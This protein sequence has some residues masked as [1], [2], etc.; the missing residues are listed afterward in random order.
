[1]KGDITYMNKSVLTDLICPICGFAL[2]V[3]GENDAS[4]IMCPNCS[5]KVVPVN[6]STANRVDNASFPDIRNAPAIFAFVDTYYESS[7]DDDFFTSAD[8]FSVKM[9]DDAVSNALLFTASEPLAW[10]AEAERI[11]LP[12]EKKLRYLE[13]LPDKI[14]KEHLEDN[15]GE[16]NYLFDIYESTLLSF[17]PYI[18][19]IKPSLD[20]ALE[21]A[22]KFGMDEGTLISL[23]ERFDSLQ[24]RVSDLCGNDNLPK[25]PVLLEAVKEARAKRD[26]RITEALIAMG[27]SAEDTYVSAM[28]L[29]KKKKNAQALDMFRQLGTYKDSAEHIAELDSYK[30]FDDIRSI[31][32]K[33]YLC[34]KNDQSSAKKKVRPV[35]LYD[36]IPLNEQNTSLI[37]IDTPV[38]KIIATYADKIYYLNREKQLTCLDLQDNVNRSVLLDGK[39]YL[40]DTDTKFHSFNGICKLAVAAREQV[41]I[42]KGR[43]KGKLRPTDTDLLIIDLSKEEMTLCDFGIDDIVCICDSYI[44]YCKDNNALS[45]ESGKVLMGYNVIT[46]KR[47]TMPQNVYKVH[48]VVDEYIIFSYQKSSPYNLSL[49]ALSCGVTTFERVLEDNVLDFSGVIDKKIYY[50]VGSYDMRILCRIDPVTLE[51]REIQRGIKARSGSEILLVREGWMYFKKG[52]GKNTVLARCHPNGSDYRVVCNDFDRFACQMPFIRGYLYYIDTDGSLCR[53]LISGHSQKVISDNIVKDTGILSF[54]GGKICFARNEYA[55]KCAV[56]KPASKKGAASTIVQTDKYSL[57]LYCCELDGTN[58]CKLCFDFDHV[59]QLSKSSLLIRR[60]MTD[61]FIAKN[62]RTVIE[63][64]KVFY[65]VLDLNE[66]SK[67][68]SLACFENTDPK[69]SAKGL[70][71]VILNDTAKSE[72]L[73]PIK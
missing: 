31:A 71:P 26:A 47:I 32:G 27:V 44:F 63:N 52:D 17:L 46:G 70:T 60:I 57:S 40:F 23:K 9:V 49:C 72:K 50:S 37:P 24:R 2:R 1:M 64:T 29:V 13:A 38:H 43:N 35:T 42:E 41:I 58:L 5:N 21:R 25:E 59:W 7:V 28:G 51:R 45:G 54:Y 68:R 6:A 14:A 69:S 16:Q 4:L 15:L 67:I 48:A 12:M 8:S 3:D 33:L 20:F 53:V 65:E 18:E 73:P 39:S 11:L 56:V 22:N 36:L 34:R 10:K 62:K 19:K 30:K 61:K 55:G 66:P